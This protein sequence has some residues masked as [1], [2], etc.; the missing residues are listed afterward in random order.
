MTQQDLV[1]LLMQMLGGVAPVEGALPMMPPEIR[2]AGLPGIPGANSPDPLVPPGAQ[3][4]QPEMQESV[5]VPPEPQPMRLAPPQAPAPA[6][7][8]GGEE[9]MLS[10]LY[11]MLGGENIPT[12]EQPTGLRR[13]LLDAAAGM[14]NIRSTAPPAAAFGAGFAG[15]MGAGESRRLA[16]EK[17]KRDNEER[18]YQR[19]KD[20]VD[21]GFRYKDDKRADKADTRADAADKRAGRADERADQTSQLNNIKLLQ[22]IMKDSNPGLSFDQRMKIEERVSAFMKSLM[23]DGAGIP[24]TA[25]EQQRIIDLGKKERE[26]LEGLFGVKPATPPAATPPAATPA[27]APKV[28]DPK[29][30]TDQNIPMATKPDGKSQQS[31]IPIDPANARAQLEKLPPGTWVIDPRTGQPTQIKARGQ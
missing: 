8:G 12:T 6:P 7:S 16:S 28:P 27:P 9:D 5:P 4:G 21:L 30:P 31:A 14:A 22:E 2:P 19:N 3:I 15:S 18:Q 20:R 17:E 24:P 29:A 23:P 1:P 10:G 26:R 25:E 11:D 13:F